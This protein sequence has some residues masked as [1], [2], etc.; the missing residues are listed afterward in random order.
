MSTA[1]MPEVIYHYTS[2]DVLLKILEGGALRLGAKHHLNDSMEGEQFFSLF[3]THDSKPDATRLASIREALGPFEFFVSCF[4][5]CGDRLSQW[6][7]YASNGSGV[8]IG[9]KRA[10]IV[11]AITGS[12]EALLYPV[13][14][15]DNLLQLSEAHADRVFAINAMLTSPGEPSRQA[16]QSFAK[17]RWAIKPS[18]FSEERE[19]RLILTIDSRRGVIQPV[20]SGFKIGYFATTTEVREFCDFQIKSLAS[21]CFLDSITLGPNNRTDVDALQRFLRLHGYEGVSIHASQLSYR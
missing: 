20:T 1:Q 11:S 4:S 13:A 15:A 12:H 14:Y 16:L 10:S 2:N 18:G 17:E 19:I 6:R 9:F 21:E 5:S 3:E 8:A 7:G